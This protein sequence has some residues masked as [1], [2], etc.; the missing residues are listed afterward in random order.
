[1]NFAAAAMPSRLAATHCGAQPVCLPTRPRLAVVA[2][3]SMEE[4]F[5]KAYTLS[6]VSSPSCAGHSQLGESKH[7]VLAE[8]RGFC[9]CRPPSPRIPTP[10]TEP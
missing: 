8:A 9:S 3:A 4:A 7:E 5:Q 6:Q 10:Q 2:R 1:M